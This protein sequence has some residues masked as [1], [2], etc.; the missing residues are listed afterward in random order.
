MNSFRNQE[1]FV[2]PGAGWRGALSKARVNNPSVSDEDTPAHENGRPYSAGNT[3]LESADEP[4]EVLHICQKDLILLWNDD[5]VREI[6]KRKKVRLEEFPG[7]F[8]NDLKRVTSLKYMPSD[9]DVLKARLKT[10]GVSEYKFEMEVTAGR[11]SGTEW[12][13]VD[14]GGSRSQRP[15]WV[16]FFD[17]V[18]AII[19]L[20]PIS[21][22]DQVLAEDR[23]VNRLE[24]SVLLWKAVCSNKLLANVDLILFLNKCDILDAKLKSGIKLSRYI[25]SYSD[26]ENNLDTVSKYLRGKFSAIHREYSPN[27]R[28]FYAFCTSV[29]DT[30]TTAGIIAS[31]RDMVIRQHLK[32]SK[33]L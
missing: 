26:R 23:T 21:S 25:K 19:F 20:A 12:R 31:V 27:P 7:F 22:F 8:L 28:K 5:V 10:V 30:T 6:L 2:R 14:V 15:T 18:D 33:L 24:D 9:D 4:Q 11:D 1:V 29:T 17:D 32:Q 16:P 13:I 3:G